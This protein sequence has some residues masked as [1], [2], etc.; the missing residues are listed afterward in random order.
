MK[1]ITMRALTLSAQQQ[2][3]QL[4]YQSHKVSASSNVNLHEFFPMFISQTASRDSGGKAGNDL[5]SSSVV[6]LV[7]PQQI[8]QLQSQLEHLREQVIRQRSLQHQIPPPNSVTE[9]SRLQQNSYVQMQ[10]QRGNLVAFGSDSSF[11]AAASQM[12]Q[13]LSRGSSSYATATQSWNPREHQQRLVN[14]AE[15]QEW[16]AT[17]RNSAS[18]A[19]SP[20]VAPV[21]NVYTNAA[22]I[23]VPEQ[24]FLASQLPAP[25]VNQRASSLAQ[26]ILIQNA[27]QDQRMAH[28]QYLPRPN[29]SPLQ[30]ARQVQGPVQSAGG[31]IPA[32]FTM[33]LE[34]VLQRAQDNRQDA[35]ERER[36]RQEI[37]QT[38]STSAKMRQLSAA[39]GALM[40]MQNRSTNLM[41][42]GLS[43]GVQR[44]QQDQ[45]SASMGAVRV[46][47]A[48]EEG[49]S[50][51]S[52]SSVPNV[53]HTETDSSDT[54]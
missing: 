53:A 38:E 8:Q 13:S 54:S 28:M 51:P 14:N 7:H 20:G 50:N 46:R 11:P 1:R 35:M 49:D 18:A 52:I 34:A 25:Q 17:L 19:F 22:A 21:P 33:V 23:A 12:E 2:R 48:M 9:S 4:V 6:S 10:P 39:W 27:G 15:L 24:P 40:A 37:Q 3:L 32:W 29:A 31:S 30:E 16:C 47:V 36:H 41:Q 45:D 42:Q 43:Q 26:H 44:V 5:N